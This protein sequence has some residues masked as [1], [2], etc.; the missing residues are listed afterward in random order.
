M[1]GGHPWPQ[2]RPKPVRPHQFLQKS[3]RFLVSISGLRVATVLDMSR[4]LLLFVLLVVARTDAKRVI[5]AAPE[6][7]KT[8]RYIVKLEDDTSHD[9]FEELKGDIIGES[10][11]H[12]IYETVEGSVSKLFSAKLPDDAL[13]RVRPKLILY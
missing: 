13:D 1:Y 10:V 6:S 8:G 3:V 12:S 11:D 5:H 2:L 7:E 4:T 9:R